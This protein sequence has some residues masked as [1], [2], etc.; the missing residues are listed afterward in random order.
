MSKILMRNG[1]LERVEVVD[2]LE[3]DLGV[4]EISSLRGWSSLDFEEGYEVGGLAYLET[5]VHHLQ[6]HVGSSGHFVK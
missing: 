2:V 6:T 5:A 4:L 3:R 1:V